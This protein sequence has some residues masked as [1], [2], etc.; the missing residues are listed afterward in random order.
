MSKKLFNLVFIGPPGGGKGTEIQLLQ[1]KKYMKISTGDLLR[2]EVGRDTKLGKTIKKDMESGNMIKDSIVTKLLN[3]MIQERNNGLIFD[4][5]PRNIKQAKKLDSILKKNDIKI[6][7][8]IHLD[9]PDKLIISRIVGRYICKKCGAS[10]NKNGVQPKKKGI[11]DVCGG[12]DFKVREDDKLTVIKKRLSEYHV[13]AKELLEY[14]N[15]K[16]LVYNVSGKEGDQNITHKEVL[17]VF[18]KLRK[19]QKE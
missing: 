4:G 13:V 5:Y 7:A 1:Q 11:C 18:K 10:Y 19:L 14:Y 16:G 6:D 17:A 3:N 15:N 9:T 2:D 12:K 8:V